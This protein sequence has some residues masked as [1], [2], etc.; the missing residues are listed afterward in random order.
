MHLP[1]VLVCPRRW[2]ENARSGVLAEFLLA[3]AQRP[4]GASKQPTRWV[5][6]AKVSFAQPLVSYRMSP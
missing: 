2:G 3:I 5:T 1:I 6:F 4:H